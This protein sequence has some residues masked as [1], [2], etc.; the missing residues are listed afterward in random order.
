MKNVKCNIEFQVSNEVTEH[1]IN[2]YL[3]DLIAGVTIGDGIP[4]ECRK[5]LDDSIFLSDKFKIGSIEIN[6]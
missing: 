5:N 2:Q 6:V 1:T 3:Y 4:Q